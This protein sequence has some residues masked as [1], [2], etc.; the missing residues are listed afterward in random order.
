MS[1]NDWETDHPS[2]G[3]KEC[4]QSLQQRLDVP[5]GTYWLSDDKGWSVVKVTVDAAGANAS[6]PKW[7]PTEY[8]AKSWVEFLIKSRLNQISMF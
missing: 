1:Y 3:W 2:N 8:A 4:E 7:F 5:G 6:K